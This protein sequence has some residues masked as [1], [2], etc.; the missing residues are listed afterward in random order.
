MNLPPFVYNR[1]QK[2][3]QIKKKKNPETEPKMT[4]VR[5]KGFS[6]C[7]SFI[8]NIAFYQYFACNLLSILS[9]ILVVGKET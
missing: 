1:S 8:N 2:L 4:L 9:Y 5:Q 6:I 7:S 3:I